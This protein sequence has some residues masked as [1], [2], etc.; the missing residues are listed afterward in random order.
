MIYPPCMFNAYWSVLLKSP[1]LDHRSYLSWTWFFQKRYQ[2]FITFAVWDYWTNFRTS[3]S[4]LSYCLCLEC[5]QW[6]PVVSEGA[7]T[8]CIPGE[9]DLLCLGWVTLTSCILKWTKWSVMYTV[10]IK[11]ATVAGCLWLW[12][13]FSH[14]WMQL[15]MSSSLN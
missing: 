5:A 7:T 11:T 12:G 4:E 6:T 2:F 14:N 9:N 13:H 10:G 8:N 3:N 1:K 15:S